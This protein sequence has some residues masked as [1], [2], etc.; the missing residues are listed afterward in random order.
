MLN[1]KNLFVPGSILLIYI[2]IF[3]RWAN[4]KVLSTGDWLYLY[5]K[6]VQEIVPFTTWDLLFSGTTSNS[7]LPRLWFDPYALVVTKLSAFIGWP[8]FERFVWFVPYLLLSFFAAYLFSKKFGF[9][10]NLRLLSGLIYSLNT[11]ILLILSGG[12]VGVMMA[13]AF[14][15]IVF[16]TLFD[17]LDNINLRKSLIFA[18]S[19]SLLIVLDLRVAYMFLVAEAL[20]V[21]LNLVKFSDKRGAK[22]L[23]AFIIPGVITLLMHTYWILPVVLSGQSPAS[24]LP[25]IYTSAS[26]LGF[27]SFAKLENTLSLLHPNWPENIFGKVSFMNPQFL[28][29][30]ILAF[31]SLLFIAKE[32]KGRRDFLLS[33]VLLGILAIFLGKGTNDPLG[34]SYTFAFNKIPGFLMFRDPTKWYAIIAVSYSILIPYTIENLIPLAKKRLSL[35]DASLIMSLLFVVL[36]SILIRDSIFGK[37][38]GTLSPTSIPANY[39]KLADKLASEKTFSRTLWI[40]AYPAFGYVSNTHPHLSTSEIFTS[41]SSAEL[42]KILKN[43]DTEKLLQQTSI[44]YVVVPEDIDGNIFV[45]DRKYDDKVYEKY[46]NG[47]RS[48]S[49]LMP[50]RGFGKIAVFEVKNPKDHFWVVGEGVKLTSKYISPTEYEVSIKNANKGDVLVFTDTYNKL[51]EANLNGQSIKSQQFKVSPNLTYNSFVLPSGT[52]KLKVV[53]KPQEWFIIGSA[54]SL[55]SF[56]VVI[57]YLFKKK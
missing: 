26:S 3:F 1:K 24:E 30:P 14:L 52:Y 35:K 12:Q 49:Y 16:F 10:N 19:L 6:A 9:E 29:I 15:P 36:W 45:K 7:D 17:L 42:I 46:L 53:Y 54:I 41:S 22:F 39:Q 31:G 5:P 34:V 43:S 56:L 32:K 27:F 20:I 51:W 28:I 25:N 33:I 11:Y 4:F 37:V 48:I 57:V 18:L 44:K 2:F 21:F 47:V 50:L 8:M 40:Q 38:N 55:V 23:Y 13:Y